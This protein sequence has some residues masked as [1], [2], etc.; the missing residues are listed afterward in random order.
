[1]HAEEYKFLD[2][3]KK[4]TQFTIPIFQRTYSWGNEQVQQLWDDIIRTGKNEKIQSHFI[5]SIVYILHEKADSVFQPA[6]VIDGQQ[7][8]T[9][10]SLLLEA[11]ARH[12]GDK[13]PYDGFSAE[14]I[15]E[16]YL[17]NR[18]ENEEKKY[19]LVLTQ[20]DK[21]TLIRLVTQKKA[22]VDPSIRIQS[23]FDFFQLK[24]KDLS[25]EL[26][27]L[28]SGLAKLM[29][30]S[31]SLT[32]GQD[33]P[34]LIFES[35][36]S[37]GKELSQ[38]DLIRNYILMD[39]EPEK[40]SELYKEYWRPM[41]ISFGQEAYE[42]HFDAFMRHYL[43]FRT[44]KI[45]RIRDVYKAF[46]EYSTDADNSFTDIRSLLDDLCRHS[47]FYGA[48]ALG[49]EKDK[50]LNQAFQDLRELNVETAYPFM[51][52]LYEDYRNEALS[53][54]DFLDILQ[55]TASYVFRR[56]ICGI[57]T[58]SLNKTF[59]NFTKTMD[60]EAYL[61]SAAAS[62]QLMPSYR[63]FPTDEEFVREIKHRDLYNFR[64]RSYWLR[65]LENHGKKEIVTVGNYTIEHIMPQNENLSVEWQKELGEDW[66][67]IHETMLHTLGNLTL[68]GYNSEYSDRPFI[69]KKTMNG[70]F[71][72][73]PLRLNEG[74]GHTAVWN[75]QSIEKRADRLAKLAKE[76]W[77]Y[78]G[79]SEEILSKYKEKPK[80]AGS[81]TLD[82]YPYL[83]KGKPSRILFDAICKEI[84]AVD[85]SVV[86]EE[87]LKYYIAYKA[88]TNFADIVPLANS[89]AITLNMPFEKIND[90]KQIAQNVAGLG[91]WG[92]G[93]VEVRITSLDQI[94]YVM[95][96][97]NQS[98][99]HQMGN[100]QEVE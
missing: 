93:E 25:S 6:M 39:L 66:Q 94:P 89:L 34:Q 85:S 21:N 28:C 71:V 15:R 7:R 86:Y 95:S 49:K 72:M 23:A 8:L 53:K 33:N 91:H 19:K 64:G 16:Y 40:Q 47:E 55:L 99:E 56:Y 1:M 41:E 79:L 48:M 35:M 57:P 24:L 2:F 32:N 20:T 13:E 29:I 92:N 50:E 9:T 96:L 63:R 61:E 97:I 54:T 76:V 11:L 30:V 84:L 45:P 81:Y 31:I 43:T 62:Y 42:Q 58:N 100:G 3:L 88:E 77:T 52:E 36:N 67:E 90:P 73:S 27:Y 10:L 68:T 80:G 60:K 22:P 98:F 59:S 83:Q 5:G 78:P 18:L 87:M 65:K 12:V 44:G 37:T 82:N 46:K 4:S 14:K 17:I 38:A 26:G 74:L 75:K 69:E 51:L 70:G